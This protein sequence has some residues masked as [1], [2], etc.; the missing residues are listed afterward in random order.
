M[1]ALTAVLLIGCGDSKQTD[2]ADTP[3]PPTKT[4][5]AAVTAP[6]VDAAP[7]PPPAKGTLKATLGGKPFTFVS[8]VA[9]DKEIGLVDIVLKNYPYT[10]KDAVESEMRPWTTDDID[11]KIHAGRYLYKDG[12]LGWAVRGIHTVSIGKKG[13]VSMNPT[14]RSGGDPLPDAEIDATA[15]KTFTIALDVKQQKPGIDDQPDKEIAAKGTIE[16]TACGEHRT[17]KKR[18]PPTPLEGGG[19]IEIAG[20]KLPIG[21]AGIVDKKSGERELRIATHEIRCSEDSDTIG[22]YSDVVVTL[23]WAKTGKL[24]SE[25]LEGYWVDSS[26]S[27]KDL[28]LSATPNRAPAGAKEIKVKLGGSSTING[29]PVTLSGSVPVTVCAPSKK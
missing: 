21:G 26:T 20:H 6:P 14:L 8:A 5:D 9:I 1:R 25:N 22:T 16:V 28:K 11:M 13:T 7:A 24:A 15:G 2:K 10:C 17:F 3:S 12:K 23:T 19:T 27:S 4:I 29:Y 18:P